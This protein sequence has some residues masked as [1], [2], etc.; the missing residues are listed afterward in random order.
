MASATQRTRALEPADWRAAV[1]FLAPALAGLGAVLVLWWAAAVAFASLRVIP[2][3]PAVFR[4]ML[5]DRDA[6]VANGAATLREAFIGFCWGN[7]AAVL[8]GALFVQY[9]LVERSLLRIAVASYCIPLVAIGPILVVVLPGDG[10]KEALAALAVFFTSLLCT[11]QGLRSA[12]P[13]SMDVVRSLGGGEAKTFRMVRVPSA[14]PSLCTGLRIAAPAALLGAVIGE[15]FGATKGLGVALV[16]AQSSFEVAR[17]WGIALCMALLAGLLYGLA[18]L[19][20]RLLVPWAGQDA[21]VAAGSAAVQGSGGLRARGA[22]L[23]TALSFFAWSMVLAIGLWYLLLRAFRLDDYF[24]KTPLDVWRYLVTD[25]AAADN[26]AELAAALRIT[27]VDAGIGYACG[28]AA[29]AIAAVLMVAV[30]PVERALMPGA[31]FM[32]SIPIV[33]VTPLITLVFGRGLLGVT[34]VVSSVVFF[35]TLVYVLAGLRDA[36]RAAGEVVAAFG[37]SRLAVVRKVRF[38]YSLPSL[39]TS[40]RNAI[41]AALGGAI[42]AE[43]LS[44]GR[45]AGNLLVV[46]YSESQFDT[47]WS[48]SVILIGV[49]A[50]CYAALGLVEDAVASRWGVAVSGRATRR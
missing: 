41:P 30:P 11:I 38:W 7:A 8:L 13:S 50:G 25:A 16:Q 47:L 1:R 28:T 43:W 46:A 17:S 2:T 26:R 31:V 6:Y 33:A 32:R 19:A 10:P 45:G 37:G 15:Y 20:S 40:A 14:L 3:P 48:G 4:Q 21:T 29:A 34:V 5:A 23:A 49:S 44:T 12:N 22:R 24:A 27:F 36:P 9:P 18:S 42:L 35:P 39:F